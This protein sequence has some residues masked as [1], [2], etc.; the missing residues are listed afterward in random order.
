MITL[1]ENG[2]FL[3]NGAP[4]ASA[5]LSP[6]EGRRRTM[7]Y[8]ILQSHSVSG[9]PGH[10]QIKFDALISHDITYVGIIQQARASGM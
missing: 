1:H 2:A 9:D 3:V 7:A 4:C 5:S 6:E 10:L 8:S